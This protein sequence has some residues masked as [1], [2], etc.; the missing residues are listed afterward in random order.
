MKTK[1]LDSCWVKPVEMN[2][3]NKQLI[4]AQ[5]ELAKQ[6]QDYYIQCLCSDKQFI[7]FVGKNYTIEVSENERI[8]YIIRKKDG[9]VLGKYNTYPKFKVR[10]K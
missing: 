6:E 5:N 3:F 7:D 2:E 10:Q 8:T 1:K 9:K 4:K